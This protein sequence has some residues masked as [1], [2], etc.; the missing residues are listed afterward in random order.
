MSEHILNSL[1]QVLLTRKGAEPS[2]SY[3]ASLYDKGAAEITGKVSEEAEE[4]NAESLRLE[5]SPDDTQ[6]RDALKNEAADLLFHLM[7]MLAYHEVT[8]DEVFEVLEGRFGKSGH[9]EK[10]SRC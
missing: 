9:E 7:V 10:A 8:P 5:K 3:V 2:E 4:T 6:I 1:Y